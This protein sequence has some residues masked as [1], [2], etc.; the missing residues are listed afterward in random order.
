ML[1]WLLSNNL[2]QLLYL[3]AAIYVAN[4]LRK[5]LLKPRVR[6]LEHTDVEGHGTLV[7]IK[8]QELLPPWRTLEETWLVFPYAE[9]ACVREGD[10]YVALEFCSSYT[11]DGLS[12]RIKGCLG[13][14]RV[15]A[16]AT[17]EAERKL[18]EELERELAK[19]RKLDDLIAQAEAK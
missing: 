10:G 15:R 2:T 14:A 7:K 19:K 13:A 1:T 6:Y 9:K 11:E 3:A 8:R 17:A 4:G 18:T 12:R 16:K 5:S